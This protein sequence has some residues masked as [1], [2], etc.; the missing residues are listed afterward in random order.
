MPDIPIDISLR[1]AKNFTLGEVVDWHKHLNMSDDDRE[2][3]QRLS[4]SALNYSTLINAT[5]QAI[6]LQGLRDYLNQ[7]F[8]YGSDIGIRVTSWL[9]HI[10]W[11]YHR[12]R[13]G[14][15]I[16]TK[17]DATDITIINLPM[18]YHSDVMNEAYR[19]LNSLQG[20]TKRYPA[21]NF[22]HNDQRGVF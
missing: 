13:D 2:L 1:L 7:E 18:I 21:M 5:H 3:C 6:R 11:E 12:N 14:S 9:R 17:G 15:S 20:F 19:Y 8:D 10:Q 22:I 4:R 16:H